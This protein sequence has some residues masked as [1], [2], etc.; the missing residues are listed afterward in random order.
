M[1]WASRQGLNEHQTQL[2]RLLQELLTQ[3]YPMTIEL[4]Q[5][6]FRLQQLKTQLMTELKTQFLSRTTHTLRM[7]RN[8]RR[9]DANRRKKQESNEW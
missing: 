1:I 9:I 2:Y 7:P 4:T 3:L 6:Y 5:L 8:G